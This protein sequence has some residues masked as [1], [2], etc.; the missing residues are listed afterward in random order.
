[1]LLRSAVPKSIGFI[2]VLG[3]FAAAIVGTAVASTWWTFV[4]Y[5]LFASLKEPTATWLHWIVSDFAGIV[6]VAPLVI[7]IATLL[8]RPPAR[9]EAVE[10]MAA[11]AV[12]AAMS[13]VIVFLPLGLW[14]T[15]VPAAL[16]FPI[17]LW[18]SARSQ[19]VFSAAGAFIVSMSVALTAI[20]GLGHFGDSGLSISAR[21][22]QT[23][24]VILVVAFGT[25]VLAA[26]F[27]E[28][29]D[30]EERL[31]S[32]NTMLADERE[33]LAHSNRMLQRERDN[34]LMSFEA[35][36][37]SISHEIAQPIGAIAMNS[38]TVEILLEK[39][40]PDH[41]KI[42]ELLSRIGDDSHR[43]TEILDGIRS[44]F[45]QVDQE[46]DLVDLN[47]IIRAVLQLSQDELKH[48]NVV[49]LLALASEL[50]LVKGNRNQLQQ[51]VFNLVHNAVEAMDAVAD[52]SRTLRLTT[53]R[54]GDN[55]IAVAVK[56]AGPGIDPDLLGGIFEAFIT[57]KAHGMGLGLAICRAIIDRHGGQLAASS[58]GQNGSQF[59]F[60][61]PVASGS[62]RLMSAVGDQADTAFASQNI[63]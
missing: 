49:C 15:V 27:A 31:A 63:R 14:E 41:K 25:A 43:T 3:L 42:R 36:T 19:P 46:H 8:R 30:S 33:R 56:D 45:K 39:T 7:A 37:A 18:L 50:P 32:A 47:E 54:R 9:R 40:P 23:E 34:K 35:I 59:Q 53:E 44:L 12:L 48:H 58:D 55:T 26:L 2:R 29:R 22:L 24:A 13:G 11:L 28:R 20:Y 4:Y 62:A 10:S 61:L 57:T 52:Q 17:L 6:S 1:M 38:E 16:V 21:V 51:V 60:V 5:D